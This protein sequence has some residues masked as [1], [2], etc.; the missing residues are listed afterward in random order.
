M[1]KGKGVAE[2]HMQ[3]RS[4]ALLHGLKECHAFAMGLCGGNNRKMLQW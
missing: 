3:A 2:R 4:R 1:R